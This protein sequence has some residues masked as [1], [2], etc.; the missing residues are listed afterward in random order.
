M[1]HSLT[2]PCPWQCPQFDLW[3]TKFRRLG[4]I[5]NVAHHREFTPPAKLNISPSQWN[6]DSISIHCSNNWLGDFRQVLPRFNEFFTDDLIIFLVFH[7]RYK[8]FKSVQCTLFD[9]RARY[10]QS[11]S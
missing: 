9:I 2:A 6:K 5:N 11:L 8:S 3:L 10:R 4:R 7:P 1:S